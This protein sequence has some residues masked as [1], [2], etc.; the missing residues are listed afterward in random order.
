MQVKLVLSIETKDVPANVPAS[1]TASATANATVKKC[2]SIP[3]SK[4]PK[5]K[6]K[7]LWLEIQ[8][9][10]DRSRSSDYTQGR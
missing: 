5:E 2:C 7:G 8:D 3:K 10:T 1:A 9:E 4:C 6:V